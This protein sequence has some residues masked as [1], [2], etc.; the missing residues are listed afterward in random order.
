VTGAVPEAMRATIRDRLDRLAAEEGIAVLLAVESGSRA[1]GFP[2]PDSDY[3]VRFLYTRP[4][5]WH[6]RVVPGPDVVERAISEEL[7]LSGWDLRKA[8]GLIL[9][10]NAVVMEWLQSPVVYAE[11]PGLREDLAA[12][13]RRALQRRPVLWH[14]LRL[15]ERQRAGLIDPEGRVRLKRYF[16]TL[17]P[18]LVLRWLRLRPAEAVP[19]MDMDRLLDGT[20]LPPDTAAEIAALTALK[21]SR[22]ELGTAEVGSP[23]IDA[24]IAAEL[25]AARAETGTERPALAPALSAEADRLHVAWTRATD[26]SPTP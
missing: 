17:R 10:S 24:L 19:P 12:F 22:K 26:R 15:G 25:D 16:Y 14:Y 5:D 13:G 8:L 23:A 6:L 18:A 1:W 20:D 11:L 2:S 21:R 4:V 9:G 7:D 3:D